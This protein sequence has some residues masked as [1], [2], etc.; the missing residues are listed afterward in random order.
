MV[1]GK[2]SSWGLPGPQKKR[3]I[4]ALLAINSVLGHSFTLEG[5][6]APCSVLVCTWALKGLAYHDF[7]AHV[8]A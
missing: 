1:G 8:C 5:P 7:G 4:T 3:R 6:K 2:K